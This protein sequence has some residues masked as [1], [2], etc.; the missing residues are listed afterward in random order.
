MAGNFELELDISKDK[1]VLKDKAITKQHLSFEIKG[2][3]IS[4]CQG[5]LRS[6]PLLQQ[7]MQPFS[8]PNRVILFVVGSRF[9]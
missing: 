9:A 5:L 7:K 4:V 8:V 6:G 2:Q 1:V 3:Q